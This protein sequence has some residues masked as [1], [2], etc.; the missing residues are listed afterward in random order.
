M[1]LV[2]FG[3]LDPRASASQ[4]VLAGWRST[5]SPA[6]YRQAIEAGSQLVEPNARVEQRAEQHVARSAAEAVDAYRPRHNGPIEPEL[7]VASHAA[8]SLDSG[9]IDTRTPVHNT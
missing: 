1:G 2:C 9:R 6:A 8:S 4:P 7:D 5:Q 3:Q